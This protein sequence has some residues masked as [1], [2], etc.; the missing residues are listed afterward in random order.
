MK[1]LICSDGS[2]QADRAIRLGAS[3]AVACQAEVTLLGI[4]EGTGD[5]KSILDSLKRGQT[6]LE[7]KKIHAELIIKTGRPIEEIV[8]RTNE[9]V[10]DL[11]VIG[12]VRKETRGA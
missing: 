2:E 10:Y 7:D 12:A 9:T 11:V 8:K 3:V 4:A 5:S 6:I 1:I